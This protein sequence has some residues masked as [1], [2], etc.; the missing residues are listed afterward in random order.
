MRNRHLR[1]VLTLAFAFGAGILLLH[2][3]ALTRKDSPDQDEEEQQAKATQTP[4]RITVR[5]GETVIQLTAAD[6]SRAGIETETLKAARERAEIT[7]PAAVLDVGSLVNLTS[8]YSIAQANLRQAENNL[9]VSEPEYERLKSL[10]AN[11]QNVSA[12]AFQAAEGAF[13]N[14]QTS[15][16]AARRDVAYQMAALRQSWGNKIAQWVADDPPTLNRILNREDV[17]V[18]VTLP[19]D[20]P[21]S[22]PGQVSLELPNQRRVMAKLVS[23][24]PQVDPRIQGPSFLYFTKQ[25]GAL[26]PGLNLIAH[27]AVGPRLSGV[28]IPRSAV[29]WLNGGS[30]VY[31]QTAPTEFTRIAVPVDHRAA[32]GFFVSKGLAAGDRVVRIGA[33][34]LLSQ[35]FRSQTGGGEEDTD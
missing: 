6:Q 15:V 25:Q 1:L 26:A 28:I 12:K 24:F 19:P 4:S 30:W 14:N 8:S 31:I 35:E 18:Q 17:L 20:G 32:D 21:G 34:A 16:A 29:V 3:F 11:Q 5:N 2:A 10:Y 27:V 9:K 23:R 13:R 7:A 33:Q 22:V